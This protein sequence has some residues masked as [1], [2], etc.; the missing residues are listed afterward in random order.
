M[1]AAAASLVLTNGKIVTVNAR[2]DIAQAVAMSGERILAVGSTAAIQPLIGKDTK[3]IDLKGRTAMP[4]LVDAHAHLDREGLKE[5]LPSMA[6]LTSIDAIVD[7]VA[8]LAARTKPGEWI[9]TMPLGDPPEFGIGASDITPPRW[10]TRHDLDRAAPNN[11]VYIKPAWGY[12]RS[13]LPLVSM[14]NSA[15]LALAG[16]TRETLP[17]CDSVRIERDSRGE[18]SGVFLD[19]NRMPVVE[20]TLMRKVPQFDVATRIAALPRS[21]QIYNSLGTTSVFEGHGVADD[22]IEAYKAVREAGRQT[23][24]ATLAFSPAWPEA[25]FEISHMIADWARSIARRGLGDEWLRI[26]GLYAEVDTSREHHLRKAVFPETGWA[27]FNYAGLPR[28]QVRELLIECARNGIRVIGIIPAMLD[29]FVEAAKVSP[30]AGQR[31]VLAHTISLDDEQL[32][33]MRDHGIVATTHTNGYIWK[34]GA[35]LRDKLGPGRENE[36]VPLRRMLDA[37]VAVA[38]GTD[39]VPVSMW[40]PIWQAVARIDRNIN[41]PVAPEQALTR[42]EALR[43]ATL[44]GAYATFEEDE[45]GSLEPGKLAD[46]TVL[47]QDPL[48]CDL[49]KLRETKAEMTIV[50]G[51]VVYERTMSD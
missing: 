33:L 34:S 11:P 44:G 51:K 25:N 40:Y 12:W 35:Q 8:E 47:S 43:C 4:G 2:F 31:W 26:N 17:P 5:A 29:L 15:A 1:T 19:H 14:A 30:I 6:G 9:I 50:G 18:P 27:G 28:E 36:V 13:S 48:T 22:V 37:G 20:F 49:A 10:P 38:F 24:R 7:R 39:N 16:I 3:V 23:V 45:K 21:M 42:E 46:M 32:A 41:A